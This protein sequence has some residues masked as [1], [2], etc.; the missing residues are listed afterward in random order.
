MNHYSH[1]STLGFICLCEV[2]V[3]THVNKVG[4]SDIISENFSLPPSP[5]V[6]LWHACKC[7]FIYFCKADLGALLKRYTNNTELK[8]IMIYLVHLLTTYQCCILKAPCLT[9]INTLSSQVKSQEA[10]IAIWIIY[11]WRS[12][13]WKETMFLHGAWCYIKQHR[14]T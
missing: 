8:I 13:H 5:L 10:L 1:I 9:C 12:T 4:L 11:S 14:A 3:N 6:C 7:Q 2:K